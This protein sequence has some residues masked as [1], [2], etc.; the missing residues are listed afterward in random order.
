MI[1]PEEVFERD[2]HAEDHFKTLSKKAKDAWKSTVDTFANDMPDNSYYAPLREQVIG[3]KPKAVIAILGN[4][5]TRRP[6]HFSPFFSGRMTI[7]QAK[8]VQRNR[9]AQR[10]AEDSRLVA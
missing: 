4:L 8:K 3:A 1:S 9:Y 10:V 6:W 2:E 7:D 5:A